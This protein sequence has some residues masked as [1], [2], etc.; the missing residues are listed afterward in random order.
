MIIFEIRDDLFNKKDIAKYV[1][2]HAVIIKH[3]HEKE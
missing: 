2:G 3:S 1:M